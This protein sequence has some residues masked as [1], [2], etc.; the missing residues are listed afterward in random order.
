[1]PVD[2]AMVRYMG[3][4]PPY[5]AFSLKRYSPRP[6]A[7]VVWTKEWQDAGVGRVTHDF[8]LTVIAEGIERL[9]SGRLAK[10]RPEIERIKELGAAGVIRVVAVADWR[11]FSRDDPKRVLT[12]VGQLETLGVVVISDAQRDLVPWQDLYWVK[13]A[14]YAEFANREAV[15]SSKAT[16]KGIVEARGAGVAWGR[17]PLGWRRLER[18]GD[19]TDPD[20][21]AAARRRSYFV[22]DESDGPRSMPVLMQA[23]ELRAARW[24]WRQIGRKFG[25]ASSSVMQALLGDV[26]PDGVR[27]NL[28]NR[29]QV[30]ADLYDLVISMGPGGE[31]AH[32]ARRPW[33]FRGLV[34]CP[35]CDSRMSGSEKIDRH[36]TRYY[37]CDNA[38][39]KKHAWTT[40]REDVLLAALRWDLAQMAFNDEQVARI[41]RA[42]R[43]PRRHREVERNR[44]NRDEI[45]RLIRKANV[46][47]DAD[48][49]TEDEYRAQIRDLRARLAEIPNDPPE[50]AIAG[51]MEQ[52]QQLSHFAEILPARPADPAEVKILVPILRRIL[53][54]VDLDKDTRRPTFTYTRLIEEIRR[55]AR[56]AGVWEEAGVDER[57]WLS[58]AEVSEATGWS[59]STV[60]RCLRAGDIPAGK[61][62]APRLG[63]YHI[64]RAWVEAHVG[65]PP[66]GRTTPLPPADGPLTIAEL[67]ERSALGYRTVLGLVRSGRVPS[68]RT[69]EGRHKRYRIPPDAVASEAITRARELSTA[70]HSRA[71]GAQGA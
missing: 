67:A 24:S 53:V 62:D 71:L 25:L 10:D 48:G 44:R 12:L 50:L 34:H 31:P 54:R 21:R 63:R 70:R 28:R 64:P 29:E 66:P 69:G 32:T 49:L 56:T 20:E 7:S 30:G 22:P 16:A 61:T 65:N 18:I 13:L 9:V 26:G 1:M 8:G 6:R 45:L 4:P 47:F 55:V 57:D 14:F 52:R 5:P 60:S 36:K 59:R 41:E 3:S 27:S 23:Y 51:L 68:E 43:T 19:Y 46:K 42:S 38:K 40:V 58:P 11:R 39:G 15:D 37:D 2:E 33:F 17:S 35:F